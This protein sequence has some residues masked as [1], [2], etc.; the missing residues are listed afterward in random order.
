MLLPGSISL[1]RILRQ[2]LR[3]NAYIGNA[4]LFHRI[5]HRGE[6]A[7]RH[8]LIGPQENGLMLGIANLGAQ[9]FR[10][11]VDVDGVIA[12]ED[13]LRFIDADYRSEER[14]VGK[15]CRSRWSPYH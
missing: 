7:E 15:E 4:G 13:T 6:C 2:W 8:I 11:L 14:R 1:N 12:Q 3:H 9:F 5:H 10:N